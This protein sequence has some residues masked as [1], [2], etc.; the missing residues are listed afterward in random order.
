MSA[1][2][3]TPLLQIRDLRIAFDTQKSSREV[4][5]GVNLELYAGSP[6]RGSSTSTCSGCT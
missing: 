2:T 3:D 5:H 6:P 4:V 1:S